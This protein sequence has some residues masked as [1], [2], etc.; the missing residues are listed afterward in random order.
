MFP[1]LQGKV[2]TPFKL[3]I[4]VHVYTQSSASITFEIPLSFVFSPHKFNSNISI[5]PLHNYIVIALPYKYS[6][7]D[8]TNFLS[9]K[10][11]SNTIP[12][13]SKTKS[14]SEKTSNVLSFWVWV[15][16]LRV[17]TSNSIYLLIIL[18]FHFHNRLI[19]Q[20]VMCHISTFHFF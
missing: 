15:T 2:I 10:N 17:S 18:W 7:M 4:Y 9:S 1:P 5:L 16:S 13:H 19:L 8:L 20:C 12:Q 6:G 3:F 14:T 11:F